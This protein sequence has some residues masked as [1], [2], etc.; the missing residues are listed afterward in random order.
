MICQ[1]DTRRDRVRAHRN[2]EGRR[3]LNGLDYVEV[4]DDQTTLTAYFLGKLPPYLRV[5][6]PGLIK[7]LRIEGGRR[8]RDIRVVDVD[9][10]VEPDPELD[11][12]LI[13]YVDKPGDFSTYTL[14]LIDLAGIDRRYDRADFSFKVNCP[15]DLDCA[16]PDRCPPPQLDEPDINYLAKD[17]ASFRQ[18]I[19]DR[20]ALIMPDWQE[21]HVPDLGIALVEVLAYAGDHLSYYQDAAATEAYLDT[22]RQRISVRR[23]TRLVDYHLHEGCNA[24]AWECV[25]TDQDFAI[26]PD[27]VYFITGLAQTANIT[28]RALIPGDLREIGVNTYEVFEPLVADRKQTLQMRAVHSQIPFYTWGERE[29]CLPQGTTSASLRDQ[30]LY[31][32]D[33][34]HDAGTAYVA[35]QRPIEPKPI[36]P[37]PAEPSI[38]PKKLKRKL[39]LHVGDVLIFEEVIG[40]KTGIPADA[41]P[42]RRCAV[43]LTKVTLNEDPV[44]PVPVAVGDVKLP[45]ATPVVDIEWAAA[46][47]LPFA[48]CLSAIVP[49]LDCQYVED[50]SVARGNVVLVDHGRTLQPPEPIGQVPLKTTQAVCECEGEPGDIMLIADRFEPRLSKA[51]LTF[52]QPVTFDHAS[53]KQLLLQDKRAAVP[54]IYLISIPGALDGTQPLFDW[55]DLNDAT[56]LAKSILLEGWSPATYH[57]GIRLSPRTQRLLSEARSP[58]NIS[59]EL[60][61]AL[62]ADLQAMLD[63]WTPQSD[64]LGSG[65]DDRHF[66]VEIDNDGVA[67]LRFGDDEFGQR[68]APGT[69]FFAV[70]RI[71][72]GT[73]GNVGADA[74]SQLVSRSTLSGP[75][76]HAR[77]PLPATGGVDPEPI[78]EAKLYAPSLFR[79]QLER[80]ITADDYAKIAKR[81]FDLALQRAAA[82]LAWTGSWYEAEVAIDPIGAET[83]SDPLEHAVATRLDHSYR[84]MGHDLRVE[85]ARYV[86]LDIEVAVC[87][88]PDYLRGHVKATLLDVFSN[89]ALPNGELGFFHPD[90]LTFGDGV[91]LS[92][93]VAAAQAVEGVDSVTVTKLQRLFEAPNQEI[94]NGVLPLG[95]F[96]IAQVDNDPSYPEHGRFTLVMQGGR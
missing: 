61:G 25:E 19:L 21:R 37:K 78:A 17:Y 2:A 52:S 45:W 51:P 72:N 75:T 29:C 22:A 64:L 70:Y 36:E 62:Q 5:D 89:R 48:L 9:P 85:A 69:A 10:H 30:W 1:D 57:R 80:A 33:K 41:D 23:H 18:L 40:P 49:A 79:K 42:R 65:P 74:I 60:A 90:R 50:I 95:P 93:I 39:D 7:H 71:G 59:N 63:C 47:A 58:D 91:Y 55:A 15:S 66:V 32:D 68:P 88:K 87:I 12:Y 13:V 20:L 54:N 4:A 83:T 46:D 94:A 43:R 8:I 38:D 76:I 84:R 27:E 35:A 67:H 3:D 53:A 86:P 26:Q 6:K 14:R 28:G 56:N 92:Q 96:E 31:Q 16:A 44:I 82:Q 73:R 77:N 34:P 24:R 81:D 11:D